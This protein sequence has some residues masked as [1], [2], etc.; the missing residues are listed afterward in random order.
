DFVSLPGGRFSIHE[1]QFVLHDFGSWRVF[2][3][4]RNAGRALQ[5]NIKTHHGSTAFANPS[6]TVL[7]SPRGRP[8]LFVTLFLPAQG[9][10]IT[11]G[12][13]LVYYREVSGRAARLLIP[14]RLR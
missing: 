6:F 14:K 10:N 2:L 12:G 9:A 11:E 8:G 13:E 3:Y 5:L 1:V 7:R 4:D